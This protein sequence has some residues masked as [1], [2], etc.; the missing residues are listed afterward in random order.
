MK[1]E[2][3]GRFYHDGRFTTLL[4]VVNHYDWH[5]TLLHL[6]DQHGPFSEPEA[7]AAIHPAE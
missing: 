7:L 2:N 1:P 3:K 4:D 6:L 5:A